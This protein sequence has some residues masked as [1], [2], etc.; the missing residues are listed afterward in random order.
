M[1][2]NFFEFALGHV[3][4]KLRIGHK[5]IAATFVGSHF[6][7]FPVLEF[8]QCFRIVAFNPAGFI[9]RHWFEAAFG[10][11]FVFQPVLNNLELKLANCSDDFSSVE[12]AGK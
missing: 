11:V 12:N 9:H 2:F 8:G 3:E 6:L 4:N 5:H 10:V 7:M 1:E